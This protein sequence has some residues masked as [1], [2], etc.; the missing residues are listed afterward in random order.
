MWQEMA[1]EKNN[2]GLKAQIDEN[3]KK[4]YEETLEEAVPDRF[5]VLLE[6]L[7]QRDAKK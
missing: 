4:V 1:G 5:K 2:S 6:K 3:L 7:S